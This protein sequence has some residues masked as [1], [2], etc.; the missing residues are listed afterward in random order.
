MLHD[1]CVIKIFARVAHAKNSPDESLKS[2]EGT[3]WSI[4]ERLEIMD[5]TTLITL[6]I[7]AL[8]G[9]IISAPF[10]MVESTATAWV[11]SYFENRILTTRERRQFILNVHY[12]FV[13]RMKE[14]PTYLNL[15]AFRTTTG[16][17]KWLAFVIGF[18]VLTFVN[19]LV[20]GSA[21]VSLVGII[22]VAFCLFLANSRLER[23]S[24]DISEVMFFDEFRE[25]TIAKLTALGGN[26]G[27][28]DKEE[29]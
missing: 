21:L 20:Q 24:R 13:K 15:V 17:L 19:L 26:Q 22:M 2:F 18:T 14:S 25:K 29:S 3:I 9:A 27:D 8:I 5:W 11:K 1:C 7:G 6:M 23:M 4:A 28:L 12:L 16:I 10:S